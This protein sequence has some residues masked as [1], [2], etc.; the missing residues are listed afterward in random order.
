MIIFLKK[1]LQD[2]KVLL[3]KIPPLTLSIFVLSVVSMN[4]LANKELFHTSWIALDCGFALSWIPFLLMDCL[5]KVFGG[6]TAAKVSILS[7]LINLVFFGIFK[8]ISLTPGMWGEYYASGLN[9]VNEA[10]NHTIG[11]SSWIVLGSAL[12]MLVSSIVNSVVNMAIGRRVGG[13]GYGHFAARS[14]ISTAIS[15]FVDNLTFAL[16]VSVPLFGWNLKQVLMCSVS[17]ATFELLMEFLFSGLGY[18][19]AKKWTENPV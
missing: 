14:F 1:E 2:Y 8:L 6:K 3:A 13:E 18:R 16:V 15:Q 11:G 10:L 7:I 19:L 5:C 17:A 9:E 12:A 4:L